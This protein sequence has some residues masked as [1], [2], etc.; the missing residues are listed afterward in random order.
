MRHYIITC[1]C[2]KQPF[3]CEIE[4]LC[5]MLLLQGQSVRARVLVLATTSSHAFASSNLPMVM[6]RAK[7]CEGECWCWPFQHHMRLLQ[8]TFSGWGYMFAEGESVRGRVLVLADAATLLMAMQ[9]GNCI[10]PL[11]GLG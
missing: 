1:V 5:C 4:H 11:L 2:F 9:M 10:N 3:Y 6:L 8:E 7:A